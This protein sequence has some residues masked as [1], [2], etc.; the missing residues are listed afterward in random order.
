MNNM[1]ELSSLNPT[2]RFTGLA[3][4]YARFRPSYPAHGI[5]FIMA[6]CGLG[7]QSLLVDVGCG[8]GIASRLFAARG[9]NVV[10]IEPNTEMRC[11][12]AAEE[13]DADSDRLNVTYRQGRAE[14]TGLDAAVA[15]A[16]LS[17]Q[18]FHWFEPVAT[19]AEFHR[20]LKPDGWAILMWNERDEQDPMTADYG[21]VI[22]TA[23]D[24]AAIEGRR[25]TRSGDS[26]RTCPLFRQAEQV[27]FH[28]H[29]VLD[30]EGLLGRAFSVSYA[31]RAANDRQEWADRLKTVFHHHQRDA[32]VVLRYRTSISLA[33][34]SSG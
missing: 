28:N 31:P 6:R 11:A 13:P 27:T 2:G 5:D 34:R 10:G 26:L 7:K 9:I 32:T 16:V 24:S 20:I 12:A 21:A 18:A 8:T 33:R 14:A 22:R 17:A 23:T 25:Q 1:P 4:T 19:L 30:E 3:G 29:Q 15:D